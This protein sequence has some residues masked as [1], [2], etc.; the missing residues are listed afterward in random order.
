MAIALP[1]QAILALAVFATR[2]PSIETLTVFLPALRLLASTSLRS[3][4]SAYRCSLDLDYLFSPR[5]R[6]SMTFA[7][8]AS[9]ACALGSAHPSR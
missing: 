2:M 7:V 9:R 1:I 8:G 5:D 3:I 4:C 6:L